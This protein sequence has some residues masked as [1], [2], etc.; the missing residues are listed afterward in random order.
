MN[1]EEITRAIGYGGLFAILFAETG[2]LIGFFLPGDTLLISA[3]LLAARGHLHIAGVLGAMI[4]GAVL[5]D[6]VGYLIGKQAGKR[7]YGRDDSFWFRRDHL[8]KARR[9]YARHG[10]KT[11]V[12]ARFVTGLR[13]FAPVV[14]GAAEMGYPRF[15]FFNVAGAVGWICSITMLGYLFGNTVSRYDHYIFIG[16]FA[17]IP[18]PLLLALSQ[19]FRLRRA[20]A[21]FHARR[22]ER[23]PLPVETEE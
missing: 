9:F 1:W 11:I 14:A 5:G 8:E 20:R 16:A 18:F 21:R 2:L 23:A 6:A 7:L 3:G 19:A 12:A 4:A 22:L 15:A 10:G 13:T 17:L